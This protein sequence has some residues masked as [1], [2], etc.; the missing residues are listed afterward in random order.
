MKKKDR[1]KIMA[2]IICTVWILAGVKG[3]FFF[4]DYSCSWM[5]AL[6]CFVYAAGCVLLLILLSD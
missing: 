3:I 1:S 6:S 5:L 2:W 4:T